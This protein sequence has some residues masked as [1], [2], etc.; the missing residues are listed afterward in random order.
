MKYSKPA[1]TDIPFDSIIPSGCGK[2]FGDNEEINCYANY[3]D[4][5]IF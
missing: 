2:E 1:S 3:M 4:D 5:H